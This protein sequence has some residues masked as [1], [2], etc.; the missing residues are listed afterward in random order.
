MWK[1]LDTG[2]ASAAENMER[3][4]ELLDSLK[5]SDCPILHF[6]DW[7][8]DSATYGYFIK[9]EA[10]IDSQKA[11]AKGLN[12]ARRPTGGGI[13]FH[14]FDLA[15][16]A[17]VPNPSPNTLENY[18][19]I[20]RAVNKAVSELLPEEAFLLPNE[21][22]P[23]T[24]SCR[25][26]CMANPTIYDVMLGKRKIAGAAQRRT[27]NGFL[28]Q[29]S[30][31]IAPPDIGYLGDILLPEAGL[32]DA[33]QTYTHALLPSSYTQSDLEEMRQ[34]LKKLLVKHLTEEQESVV[35]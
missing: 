1:I 22:E 3:D 8:G 2:K 7:D 15:F 29:G 30:I 24:E 17:L 26:F 21:P 27:K 6:Y 13:I 14:L 12:L 11:K 23:E 5:P 35:S 33:M 34:I 28:H 18:A 4:R 16:S 10:F 9:P 19:F 20:N 31:A 25:F 32:L